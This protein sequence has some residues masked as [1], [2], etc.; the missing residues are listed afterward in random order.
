MENVVRASEDPEHLG[1]ELAKWLA[2]ESNDF[3]VVSLGDDQ[4]FYAGFSNLVN[5]IKLQEDFDLFREFSNLV[6]EMDQH[7]FDIV[8]RIN[9]RPQVFVG[10]DN[11]FSDEMSLVVTDVPFGRAKATV[12]LLGPLRMDYKENLALLNY[13]KNK[14]GLWTSKQ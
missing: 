10:S 3:A 12:G 4:I 2:Q 6:D 9:G 13:V 1:R 5:K 14:M 8:D 11:Q 7:F